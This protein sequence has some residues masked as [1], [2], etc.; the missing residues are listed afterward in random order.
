MKKQYITDT[1][2]NKLAVIIP[3]AEYDQLMEDISNLATTAKRRNEETISFE[4]VKKT[5]IENGLHPR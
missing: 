1:H 5:L 4:K 2:G 3:I